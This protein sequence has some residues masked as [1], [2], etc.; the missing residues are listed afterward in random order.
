MT[1]D[2]PSATVYGLTLPSEAEVIADLMRLVGADVA[3][4]ASR[5]ASDADEE[6]GPRGYVELLLRLGEQLAARSDV[7]GVFGRSLA[8]RVNTYI[9]LSSPRTSA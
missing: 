5:E 8:V 3:I 1:T 9:A 4:F 6:A 7:A 2:Q